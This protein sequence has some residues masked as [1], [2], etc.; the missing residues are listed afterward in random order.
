MTG[1]YREKTPA[2]FEVENL[3]PTKFRIVC[4][5]KLKAQAPQ[6]AQFR[7]KWRIT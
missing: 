1:I 2:N 7:P 5:A 3:S 4:T 6:L